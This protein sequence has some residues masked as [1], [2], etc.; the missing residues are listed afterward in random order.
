MSPWDVMRPGVTRM[1]PRAARGGGHPRA[2]PTQGR[3]GAAARPRPPPHTPRARVETDCRQNVGGLERPRRACASCRNFKTVLIEGDDDRLTLN[4]I[5][6]QTYVVRR[7]LVT[8]SIE[9]RARDGRQHAV[10]KA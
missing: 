2:P 7:P 10:D 8:R 9:C 4:A 1:V 6:P 3:G 5:E